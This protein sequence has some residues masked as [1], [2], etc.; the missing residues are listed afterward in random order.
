MAGSAGICRRISRKIES[1]PTPESKTPM[2]R[3]ARGG[4][5]VENRGCTRRAPLRVCLG[6]APIAA[7]A[8]LLFA[9]LFQPRSLAGQLAQIVQLGSAHLGLPLHFDF[10]DARRPQQEGPFPADPMRSQPGA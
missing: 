3:G 9:A 6:C 8:A 1:P 2:S 4:I 7:R 5:P 10:L